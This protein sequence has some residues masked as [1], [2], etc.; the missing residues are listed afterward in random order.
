VMDAITNYVKTAGLDPAPYQ[1]MTSEYRTAFQ[2]AIK[3]D[4]T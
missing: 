2:E 4:T 3:R 1:K